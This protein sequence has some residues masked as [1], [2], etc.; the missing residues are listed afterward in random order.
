[1]RNEQSFIVDEL[2]GLRE[3]VEMLPGT[4]SKVDLYYSFEHNLLVEAHVFSGS[5]TSLGCMKQWEE[6][7]KYVNRIIHTCDIRE[8][9]GTVFY[10]TE[11]GFFFKYCNPE[12]FVKTFKKVLL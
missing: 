6:T 4:F 3:R 8:G 1:M 7:G 5:S 11:D 2:A 9:A 10:M 12:E